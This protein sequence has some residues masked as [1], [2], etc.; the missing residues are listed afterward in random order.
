MCSDPATDVI[1]LVDDSGSLKKA[2]FQTE[3]DFAAKMVMEF[4]L[5]PK[6]YQAG[7][8]T[9]SDGI[10]SYIQLGKITDNNVFASKIRQI[11]YH[12][13]LTYLGKSL[14]MVHDGF[15]LSAGGRRNVRKVI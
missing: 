12:G 4:N 7:I 8:Y 10:T 3:L 14:K 1:I 11:P 6:N 2:E 13:G 15:T 9:F 5:G